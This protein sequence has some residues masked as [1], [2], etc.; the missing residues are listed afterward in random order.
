MGSTWLASREDVALAL[1]RGSS[2]RDAG[3]LDRHVASATDKIVQYS[4]YPGYAPFVGTRYF[5]W[6]ADDT[7]SAYA[8]HRLYL[9][10]NILISAT[11]V[12]AG[13]TAI[14]TGAGGYQAYP[15]NRVD[16]EP[17]RFLELDR[18]GSRS[19]SDGSTGPQDQVAVTG[20]WGWSDVQ[21]AV[22]TLDGPMSSSTTA[23]TLAAASGQRRAG[24]GNQLIVDNE[25]MIVVERQMIDTGDALT[26]D[27]AAYDSSTILS[28]VV[29]AD[30]T[31]Y[32]V[33]ETIAVDAEDMLIERIRANTLYVRRGWGGSTLENHAT[34]ADIYADRRLIVERG[35][36]GTTAATHADG[37]AVARWVE[38][39]ALHTLCI[40]LAIDEA[41]QVGSAYARVAGSG[42]NANEMRGTGVRE[43]WKSAGPYFRRG[44]VYAV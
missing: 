18:A 20:T 33:G 10:R 3:A 6:P 35:A 29:V 19:W 44:R 41:H 43:A 16:G 38:P 21:V 13:G 36:A 2:V 12:T 39:P 14:P 34:G 17:V 4:G 42:E 28:S 30:G 25:R 7:S 1:D 22:G 15:R 26:T 5:A 9:G 23:L 11:Q 27:L 31:A 32:A 24:V 40:A 37:A 8:T